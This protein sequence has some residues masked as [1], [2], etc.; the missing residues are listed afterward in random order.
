MGVACGG[1]R[2]NHERWKAAWVK[3]FGGRARHERRMTDARK[4]FEKAQRRYADTSRP[5]K[6]GCVKRLRDTKPSSRR[7]QHNRRIE[8][9]RLGHAGLRKCPDVLGKGACEDAVAVRGS[10][11]RLVLVAVRAAVI[12][13]VLF[14]MSLDML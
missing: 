11:G 4:S 2:Y 9:S 8:Q 3:L 13:R 10:A 5:V 12:V 14:N 1:R 7:K 6:A